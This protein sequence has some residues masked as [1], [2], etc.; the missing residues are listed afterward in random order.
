MVCR[1]RIAYIAY[2]E[3]Y[4]RIQ[5]DE[6]NPAANCGRWLWVVC[7]FCLVIVYIVVHGGDS[8]TSFG[9]RS[10]SLS[11]AWTAW[12]HENTLATFALS[13]SFRHNH[14][15]PGRHFYSREQRCVRVFRV[16]VFGWVFG[17]SVW[18]VYKSDVVYVFAALLACCARRGNESDERA[19]KRMACSWG[20]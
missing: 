19:S 4:T 15:L 8:T 2:R 10:F 14:F 20:G 7:W 17:W 18:T 3:R 12:A 11:L 1:S 16:A 5:M 9:K 6:L 13:R